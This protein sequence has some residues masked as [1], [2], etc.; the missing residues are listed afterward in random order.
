MTEASRVAERVKLVLAW[1][2]VGIPA[3]WGVAQVVVKSA[4]LFR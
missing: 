2:F 3:A 4:A 1:L